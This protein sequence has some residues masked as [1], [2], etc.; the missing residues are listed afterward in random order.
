MRLFV[1]GSAK[2]WHVQ[3]LLAGARRLGHEAQGVDFCRLRARLGNGGRTL[4]AAATDLMEADA[5]LV[6]GVPAGNLEQIVFRMDALHQLEAAGVPVINPARA[7]ETCVD[8]YLATARLAAAGLPVPRTIVC[9]AL[10]DGLAA[11]EELGGDVVIKPLFGSEGRGILRA[12]SE[13]LAY[14]ILWTLFKLPTILYLQEFV[15][16]PGHD[17][18]AFVIG[19]RVVAAMKRSAS[20][21]FRTNVAQ[22]GK[23]EPYSL[24]AAWSDLARRAAAAVGA[25][26]AGVDL[27]PDERG[28]PLVVEVNSAPGFRALAETTPLDLPAA[29]MAFAAGRARSVGR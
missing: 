26:V 2:S 5:V 27:L 25:L 29:I 10:E 4:A 28:E 14:R 15:P 18:R 21:D 12:T 7:I 19:D 23:F 22:G 13:A 24:P 11:F 9:E 1:L 8:K 16:H 17:V 3:E 6:R 20:G